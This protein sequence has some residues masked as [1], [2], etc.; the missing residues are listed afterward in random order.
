MS[1]FSAARY[2]EDRYRKGGISGA[3][4]RGDEAAWKVAQIQHVITTYRVR[5][6]LDLG[7]GDGVVVAGLRVPTYV[8]YDVAP[9]AVAACKA[10]MPYHQFTTELP[11]ESVTFD[12]TMSVDVL[13]HLVDPEDFRAHLGAL[14]S[15][16]HRLVLIY[17]TD[18][19]Q[20]GAP[21]VLHRAWTRSWSPPEGWTLLWS[22]EV[23]ADRRKRIGLFERSESR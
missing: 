2:W 13:F 22:E 4:S 7:C 14:F 18:H 1:T 21:H 19:D 17:A 5:S 12:M 9:T 11:P 20:R 3:G 6:L 23:P 15:R 10:L 16:S 8:G